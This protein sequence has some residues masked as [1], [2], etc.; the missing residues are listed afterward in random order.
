MER[1]YKFVIAINYYS[2]AIRRPPLEL[3][4]PLLA[5]HPASLRPKFAKLI[6]A[7]DRNP[8][9][10]DEEGFKEKILL[11]VKRNHPNFDEAYAAK[12]V[13]KYAEKAMV[14]LDALWA[15]KKTGFPNRNIQ[16]WQ[17]SLK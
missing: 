3:N 7:T 6:V 9:T 2:K 13:D 8:R 14:V 12:L 17:P 4:D 11:A 16:K 1:F 15:V 5:K 10:V